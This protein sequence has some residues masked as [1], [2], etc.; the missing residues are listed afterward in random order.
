M[1]TG[2]TDLNALAGHVIGGRYVRGNR[3]RAST[4]PHGAVHQVLQRRI[5]GNGS[6]G[7]IVLASDNSGGADVAVKMEV[8]VRSELCARLAV[9]ALHAACW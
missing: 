1:D 5:L 6:F 7:V 4:A 2:S 8:C 9:V 3:T